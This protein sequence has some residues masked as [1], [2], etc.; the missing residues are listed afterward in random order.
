MEAFKIKNGLS[1]KRYLGST[2][3]DGSGSF[4]GG[5]NE[6]TYDSIEFNLQD[7]AYAASFKPDGLKM[8]SLGNTND[9]VYQYSLSTAWDLSTASYDSVSFSVASQVGTPADLAFNDSGTKMYVLNA[10]DSSVY[11]YTLSTAF[12]L[13]TASYDSVSFS[14]AS[15]DS[16]IHAMVLKVDGTKFYLL[17]R[18]NDTIYQYSLS[19]AYDLSTASYDSVSFSVASQESSPMSMEFTNTGSTLFIAGIGNDT[20]FQYSLSTAWDVSTASYD[21]VSLG[22]VGWRDLTLSS[23]DLKLYILSTGGNPL[24]QYSLAVNYTQALDLSTGTTFSFTPS[25]A[26]TVSF[27]N[28]PASGNAIGFSVEI[29]GDGSAITWPS[30]VKWDLATAPVAL[31]SKELYTFVTTDGGTTYYGK[32]AAEGLA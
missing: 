28:P 22:T 31:A 12:D 29:N 15:Q 7:Y 2:G 27:T 13:S 11:Q 19:T 20:I 32:K 5:I 18:G 10:G 1:A 6:A 17:G 24:R 3:A 23:D 4:L 16:E 30:S 25:G 14:A 9:S 21:N 8:Y 26:T